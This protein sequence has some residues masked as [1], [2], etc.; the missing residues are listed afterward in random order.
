M[1]FGALPDPDS[2]AVLHLRGDL[3]V[4]SAPTLLDA[5]LPVLDTGDELVLELSALTFLDSSGLAALVRLHKR[6][7]DKGAALVLRAVPANARR[8]LE[9]TSLDNVFVVE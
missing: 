4:E 1:D 2:P 9:I 8:I 7:V 5:A 3:D 6:L